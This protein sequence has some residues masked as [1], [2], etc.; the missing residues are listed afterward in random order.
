LDILHLQFVTKADIIF[1]GFKEAGHARNFLQPLAR[2]QP[3]L[4]REQ[5]MGVHDTRKITL[6]NFIV[7]D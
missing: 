1:G 7:R 5:N 3:A 4:R 2:L 6:C